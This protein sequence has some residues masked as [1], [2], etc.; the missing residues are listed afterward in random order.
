MTVD[1]KRLNNLLC[2][3]IVRADQG[4]EMAVDVAFCCTLVKYVLCVL[5]IFE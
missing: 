5:Q 2:G 3:D 1:Y 4:F